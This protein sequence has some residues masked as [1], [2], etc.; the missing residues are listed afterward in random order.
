MAGTEV[1]SAAAVEQTVVAPDSWHHQAAKAAGPDVEKE[2]P[3]ARGVSV[4]TRLGT[5]SSENVAVEIAVVGWVA[6]VSGVWRLR[7]CYFG[8]S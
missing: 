2:W 4:H 6:S 7:E 3:D 8:R 5:T 1:E